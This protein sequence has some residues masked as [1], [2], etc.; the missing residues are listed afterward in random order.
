LEALCQSLY[1][2]FCHSHKR[3][4]ELQKLN[5]LM[6]TKGL[7]MVR[8]AETRWISMRSLAQR[9]MAKYKTLL[10]KMDVDMATGG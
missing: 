8:K 7:K 9:I 4:T 2:Y 5:D 1:S 6:E 3:H 10:V